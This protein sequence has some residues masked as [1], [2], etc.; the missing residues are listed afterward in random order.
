MLIAA[1]M[2]T[3]LH[4]FFFASWGISWPHKLPF[5]NPLD[6]TLRDNI[7]NEIT[8]DR[9]F[10]P[11]TPFSSTNKACHLYIIKLCLTLIYLLNYIIQ[12]GD[13]MLYSTGIYRISLLKYIIWC[14]VEATKKMILLHL[15]MLQFNFALMQVK[16]FDICILI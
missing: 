10:S 1:C 15:N 14:N 3:N 9:W 13:K 7:L 5:R 4:L 12:V 16:P 11:G 6:T 8:K 2:K